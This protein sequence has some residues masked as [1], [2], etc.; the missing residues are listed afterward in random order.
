[1]AVKVGLPCARMVHPVAAFG[2]FVGPGLLSVC[3]CVCLCARMRVC[4]RACALLQGDISSDARF[5]A[6]PRSDR[7][8]Y[9]RV[10]GPRREHASE[11]RAVGPSRAI[12]PRML[13][14]CRLVRCDRASEA[15]V[16]GQPASLKRD[17]A[18][19]RGLGGLRSSNYVPARVRGRR[20]APALPPPAGARRRRVAGTA[21][22]P[23][24]PPDRP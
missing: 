17:R 10:V 24:A 5:V 19:A 7:A 8:S 14:L 11:G 18:E 21:P 16:L 6:P 23:L 9:A 22:H 20:R 13:A 15:C 2:C 1:M 4:V 12:A 3:L